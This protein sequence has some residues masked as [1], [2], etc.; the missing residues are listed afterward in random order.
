MSAPTPVKTRA[1][2]KIAEAET[3]LKEPTKAVQQLLEPAM[4]ERP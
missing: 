2:T 1:R 3:P 4:E